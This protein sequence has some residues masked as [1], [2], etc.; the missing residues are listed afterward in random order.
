MKK[1]IKKSGQ[2]QQAY[3]LGE[4]HEVLAKL[5]EEGKIRKAGA[6]VYEV[7]SREAVGDRGEIAQDGDY[8][9]LDSEGFP[10]PNQAEFFDK[11]HRHIRGNV[12]EQLP[13]P[14]LAWTKEDEM[15]DEIRFLIEKKG[16]V[17]KKEEPERYFTA[18]LWKTLLCAGENAVLV[19]Y[20]IDRDEDGNILDADFNFV[21]RSEFERN[22]DVIEG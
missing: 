3:R 22:Y 6:G 4:E 16:L 2:E 5:M 7:F 9:K 14:L 15:C 11:N 13:K 10:Y 12:Y 21:E 17:L 18:F 8:I 1:V 19:F 20:R